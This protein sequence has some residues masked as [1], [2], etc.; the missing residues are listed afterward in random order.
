M[1]M[2]VAATYLT[3]LAGWP[4]CPGEHEESSIGDGS[5]RRITLTEGSILGGGAFSRVFEV[6]GMSVHHLSV[7][8]VVM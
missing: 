3:S 6:Q 1:Q 4:S 7:D 5:T 8:R 2:T